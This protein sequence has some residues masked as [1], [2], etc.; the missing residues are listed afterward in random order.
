MISQLTGMDIP[1][2]NLRQWMMGL[3]GDATDYQLND[4]FQL[5]SLTYK[6]DGQTWQ[7]TIADY[8]NKVNPPL[9]ASLEL[10]E[11]DQRI[12][13]RMDNWTLK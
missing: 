5:S 6:H 7:V 8:D 9:P 1:L 2:T 13:L 12:K 11:G 10:K 3:P 4:Q